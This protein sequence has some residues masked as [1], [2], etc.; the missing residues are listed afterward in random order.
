MY[1]N[2]LG[3]RTLRTLVTNDDN[4]DVIIHFFFSLSLA[5]PDHVR[6]PLSVFFSFP[7]KQKT[8]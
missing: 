3:F 5:H 1:L 8:G 7:H 6:S 2:V 4:D